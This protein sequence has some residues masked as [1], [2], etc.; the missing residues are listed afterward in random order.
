MVNS[1]QDS[2]APGDR[3]TSARLPIHEDVRYKILG[4]GKSVREVRIG[5]VLN[6]SSSGVLF[7]TASALWEGER[8]ELT[9]SW[10]ARLNDGTRLKL[11]I[12]GRVMRAEE[13]QA[14]IAI[15]KYEFKT[16]ALPLACSGAM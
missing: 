1:S 9:V 10:P 13:A 8:V 6:M 7:S 15:E 2:G 12:L 16:S 14:A 4:E 3:R 5:K 11:V